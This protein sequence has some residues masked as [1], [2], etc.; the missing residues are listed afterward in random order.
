MALPKAAV[1]EIG[2]EGERIGRLPAAA[3][4]QKLHQILGRLRERIDAGPVLAEHLDRRRGGGAESVIRTGESQVEFGLITPD[5][6]VAVNAAQARRRILAPARII[7]GIG[8]NIAGRVAI[9]AAGLHGGTDPAIRAATQLAL[10]ALIGE[11]VFHLE[12]KRA[13]Q[14]VETIDGIAGHQRQLVDRLFG[15]EIPIDDVAEHFVDTHPVLIDGEALRR[16]EDGR[17]NEAT[18]ID[19]ELKLI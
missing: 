9:L 4:R 19:A 1:I 18:I 7:D 16:A 13:A 2:L 12:Q 15:D 8:G 11:A 6:E 17:R 10:D 3:T 5:A 14:R